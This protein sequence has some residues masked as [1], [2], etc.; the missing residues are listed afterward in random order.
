MKR[1]LAVFSMIVL[2]ASFGACKPK[3]STYRQVYEKAKQ[4]EIATN[5]NRTQAPSVESQDMIVSKPAQSEVNVRRERLTPSRGEDANRLMRYSVVI[6]SFQERT[7]A[8]ALKTRMEQH[9][10]R[11]VLA[12]NEFG[13]IRVIAAS[14]NTRE[15]AVNGR[16]SLKAQFAP[17]FQDA[18]LLERDAQ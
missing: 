18:W 3:Q 15:E 17:Q 5:Q 16:E 14:Y 8:V 6:G 11:A 12:E 9:G 2:V 4:R 1:T 7:N 13:M 10:Y